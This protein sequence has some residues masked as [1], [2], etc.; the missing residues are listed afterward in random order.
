MTYASTAPQ[1]NGNLR[2]LGRRLFILLV[3]APLVTS[4]CVD[5]NATACSTFPIEAC[6]WNE[7]AQTSCPRTCGLCGSPSP[8][9][10]SP[11]ACANVPSGNWSHGPVHLNLNYTDLDG[12]QPT[13][14]DDDARQALDLY[15]TT[16]AA[17]QPTPV[18]VAIFVHGGGW[19]AKSRKEIGAMDLLRDSLLTAGFSVASI[20]YR[21]SMSPNF[22]KHPTQI[23]DV[24]AGV[25]YLK[26]NAHRYNLDP[27]Y[28]P[29][30]ASFASLPSRPAS[31]HACPRLS[32][33]SFLAIHRFFGQ[34]SR[35]AL[36]T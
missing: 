13:Y 22:A 19:K 24:E 30:P 34:G 31:L 23:E 4:E 3:A 8:P 6:S 36:P 20:G 14:T 17:L 26:A 15:E 28:A 25:R 18:P 29:L 16:A 10:S 12:L 11:R 32:V 9:P 27:R 2:F 5:Q 33:H 7:L 21:L 1:H 35:M